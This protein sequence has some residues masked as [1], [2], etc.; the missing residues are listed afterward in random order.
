MKPFTKNM[1]YI[2]MASCQ[3]CPKRMVIPFNGEKLP[4]IY[5]AH[6]GR[7]MVTKI[8][9]NKCLNRKPRK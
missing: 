4:G 2:V 8:V 1:T 5:C 6:C 3:R 9:E 7:E